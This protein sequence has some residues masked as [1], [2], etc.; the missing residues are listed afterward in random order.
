MRIKTR[1]VMLVALLVVLG[2]KS[3]EQAGMSESARASSE[4]MTT[5]A[6]ESMDSAKQAGATARES[7]KDSMAENAENAEGAMAEKAKEVY[8]GNGLTY[9]DLVVGTGKTAEAGM[10]ASVH[11]TGWL[12]DGTKFDSSVDRG[13]PFSFVIGQGQ[14]IRGWDEGVKGMK[15]GGKRKL[16]IPPQLG[17]GERGYPGVIPPNATLVFEVEL[18]DLQ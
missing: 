10:R 17:Y 7:A 14:V 4:G 11:Y 8:L 3:G 5:E 18:L 13:Q 16:T 1:Y 12:A 15:V 6:T 2:C 9:Q